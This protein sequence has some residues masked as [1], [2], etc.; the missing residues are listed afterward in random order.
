MEQII[1]TN[2]LYLGKGLHKAAWIHPHN[3]KR[4]IKVPFD[5]NDAELR[6]ELTYRKVR[7]RHHLNSS[8]LTQYYGTVATNKGI[9]YVFERVVNERDGKISECQT[10]QSFL[11]EE[12]QKA[13]PN[14]E[15]VRYVLQNLQQHLFADLILTNS[16]TTVNFLLQ[17][18]GISSYPRVRIIDNIGSSVLIP[19]VYYSNF[20]AKK[21]IC[22][23]WQRFT[24]RICDEYPRLVKREWLVLPKSL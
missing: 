2:D 22:R 3:L 15:L 10:M 14:Y 17:Y 20:F 1:L 24:A 4:C 19:L 13:K 23:Y 21:H 7:Q 18:V 9:G 6:H 8:V 5:P 16:T 11:Q 12:N